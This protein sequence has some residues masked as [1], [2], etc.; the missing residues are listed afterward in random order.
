M[1]KLNVKYALLNGKLVERVR[2]FKFKEF[3]G[4]YNILDFISQTDEEPN[5]M[6]FISALNN[7]KKQ[8]TLTQ[9]D[10]DEIHWKGDENGRGH[11]PDEN[12]ELK[13][14]PFRK[15]CP[16]STHIIMMADIN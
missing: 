5:G 13:K 9:L 15:E 10:C 1:E 7:L 8:F 11:G 16:I 2:N 12:C 6:F 14:C 4:N 3:P